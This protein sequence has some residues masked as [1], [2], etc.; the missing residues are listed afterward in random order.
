MMFYLAPYHKKNVLKKHILTRAFIFMV[1]LTL[2][3]PAC[4]SANPH[5]KIVPQA[6]EQTV[7]SGVKLAYNA[8]KLY[9]IK[10]LLTHSIL[11]NFNIIRRNGVCTLDGVQELIF[12]A[13]AYALAESIYYSYEPTIANTLAYLNDQIFNNHFHKHPVLPSHKPS[14]SK[15]NTQKN[16][17]TLTTP[18]TISTSFQNTNLSTQS[19]YAP[20][21]ML[22]KQGD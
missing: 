11:R 18:L 15:N 16:T 1:L 10:I 12:F 3:I 7:H 6:V 4:I 17:N 14:H 19:E 9:M 20:D 2:I 8:S 21:T 22:A 13:S 5:K